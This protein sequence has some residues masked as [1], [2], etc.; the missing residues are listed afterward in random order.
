MHD[1]HRSYYAEVRH[2]YAQDHLTDQNSERV[3][4]NGLDSTVYLD[5]LLTELEGHTDDD[6]SYP[7]SVDDVKSQLGVSEFAA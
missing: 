3:A 5:L 2:T 4:E 7:R 6:Q 1:F